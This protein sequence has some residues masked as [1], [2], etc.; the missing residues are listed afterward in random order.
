MP[1]AKLE[2]FYERHPEGGPEILMLQAGGVPV[3]VASAGARRMRQ[4]THAIVAGA[5]T[6]FVVAPDHRGL[7]PA[8]LLQ[9]R[10][11]EVGLVRF[12]V[13]FGM[14]NRQSEAVVRR[15]GYRHVGDHVRR[16][17]V[18]RSGSY[19]ARYVPRPLSDL[20]GAIADRARYLSLTVRAMSGP[21]LRFAWIE[22]PDERFDRLW[23]AAAGNGALIGVRD[24]AF[25]SWRFADNP[26]CSHRFFVAE[27][28]GDEN[29]LAAYAACRVDEGTLHVSDFLC[30]PAIAGAARSLWLNLAR[31]A[32][33]GGHR[34]LSVSFLGPQHEQSAIEA[35][36]LI[37]RERRP[38]YAAWADGG[39]AAGTTWYLTSADDDD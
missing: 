34:S 19:L 27:V 24:R 22:R 8:L 4:G 26:L 39:T 21:R 9:R 7:F 14:P 28:E 30:D 5:L 16:A 33:D 20:L 37:P 18:L 11:R 31:H 32:F 2:W 1:E 38:V 36:G 25:L 17:R 29:R 6:D 23:E 15:L 13:L 35:A 12:P 3:G 10:L